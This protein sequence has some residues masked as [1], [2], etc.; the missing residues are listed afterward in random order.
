MAVLALTAAEPPTL[1][2]LN[3]ALLCAVFLLLASLVKSLSL[4]PSSL[5]TRVDGVVGLLCLLVVAQF[6]GDRLLV[7]S[8]EGTVTPTRFVQFFMAGGICAFLTH[9]ACTPI[10]VVKTRIQT[11]TG[12]YNG[13]VDAFRK[14]VAEEGAITLLKGLAPT[15]GG[16]FLHGAF[17][18]SFYEVFKVLLSPDAATALKPPLSIAAGAGF[19]AECIACLLLCPMEAIRIRSVAD[20]TFPN[21]VV[22]GLSLL[23][24]GEGVHGWYKGLPAMLMKQVPYTVGQF[25]SFELAVTL[26]KGFVRTFLGM[27]GESAFASVSSIAGLLAGITAAIISH[28]GDTILSKI[29]QEESEGS[30]WAQIVRVARAAGFA[31]LFIGLGARVL[32]V[33]C[34]IGGQFLIY[35]SIKLWCGIVPASATVEAVKRTGTEL[36]TNALLAGGEVAAEAIAKKLR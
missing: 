12:R 17:K 32:Q 10:D 4:I 8:A 21:G 6:F 15:A 25:V 26:V 27:E 16:Y 33:S 14:I 18:Y 22:T 28:P 5:H 30:A 13:M 31:G 34:M 20:A 35:D 19:F 24:K 2:P 1:Q 36:A 9:A 3:V 23:L 7:A 11:T 29:N